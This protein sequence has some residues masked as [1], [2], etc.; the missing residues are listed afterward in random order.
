MDTGKISGRYAKAIYDF[1]SSKGQE[2]ILYSEMRVLSDSFMGFKS[3]QRAMIEPSL[4]AEEKKKLLI[5]AGGI[6]VSDAYLAWVNLVST[7]KREKYARNMAL[8]FQDY[9][10]SNKGMLV[11][12]LISAVELPLEVQGKIRAM[13][14]KTYHQQ[15]IDFKTQI[16]PS[17]IG[18]FVL[19]INAQ[20]MD[21]SVK[22]QLRRLR[23]KLNS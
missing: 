22:D 10:R 1:A 11:G 2:D 14:T 19:E 18:G 17:L 15:S 16:D 8:M 4:A 23:I 12:E 21:A 5:T 9:Y 7:N 3:L 20:R 6:Q 13:L